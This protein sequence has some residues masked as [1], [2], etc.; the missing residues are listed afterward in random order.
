[1]KAENMR[2]RRN[3][4]PRK[5][6][7]ANILLVVLVLTT[8]SGTL[9]VAIY[10]FLQQQTL[11]RNQVQ[12]ILGQKQ[13]LALAE[14]TFQNL[15]QLASEN[16]IVD[17]CQ[18]GHLHFFKTNET[19]SEVSDLG[20]LDREDPAQGWY[21]T[22]LPI[23]NSTQQPCRFQG[24]GLRPPLSEV[25]QQL[26]SP[27]SIQRS[28]QT[29]LLPFLSSDQK[30]EVWSCWKSLQKDPQQPLSLEHFCPFLREIHWQGQELHL[31]LWNP[32][33]R[34][35]AGH[36]LLQMS[37]MVN[38]SGT[39]REE[40]RSL[41]LIGLNI[42]PG[43]VEKRTL[44]LGPVTSLRLSIKSLQMQ[45]LKPGLYRLKA[46]DLSQDLWTQTQV[47]TQQSRP[48]PW[49]RT[50]TAPTNGGFWS[51]AVP[52]PFSGTEI[53]C[54]TQTW[55]DQLDACLFF[56]DGTPY[57]KV[58][59]FH[60][61]HAYIQAFNDF[62]WNQCVPQPTQIPF[63]FNGMRRVLVY[64]L[65]KLLHKSEEAVIEPVEKILAAQPFPHAYAFVQWAQKELSFPL[66]C[67]GN[68]YAR[69]ENFQIFAQKIIGPHCYT[70]SLTV[71]RDV[72]TQRWHREKLLFSQEPVSD[73]NCP[74]DLNR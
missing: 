58:G 8:L 44:F 68:L 62:L 28:P 5:C 64:R 27:S 17:C 72:A 40:D 61:P 36:L 47:L 21:V 25:M 37:V 11:L 46:L 26:A 1:M 66:T 4:P 63:W 57:R 20:T 59:C 16:A 3:W 70:C 74:Q 60:S 56:Q 55:N 19:P 12:R 14:Y 34:P 24:E 51:S 30:H 6:C 48:A 22:V 50:P 15:Q 53:L 38:E 23:Y 69:S 2:L 39:L 54:P 65:S 71:K 41:G 45:L 67:W 9:T 7:S 32:Y 10:T 42:A 52:Q 73:L 43:G 29:N 13:T 18:E 31:T 49:S 33:D 35:L